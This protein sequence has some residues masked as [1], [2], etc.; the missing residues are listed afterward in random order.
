[1]PVCI[2]SLNTECRGFAADNFGTLAGDSV[3]VDISI[4]HIFEIVV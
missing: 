3:R 1:M 4:E 2:S